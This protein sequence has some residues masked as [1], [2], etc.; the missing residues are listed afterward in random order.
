MEER[1]V[2]LRALEGAESVAA[3]AIG[4][5]YTIQKVF[6]SLHASDWE[7]VWSVLERRED[8][9][10]FSFSLSF[11]LFLFVIYNILSVLLSESVSECVWFKRIS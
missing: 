1:M 5:P 11:F 6:G 4:P 7:S 8:T 2:S 10:F 3:Q 9:T